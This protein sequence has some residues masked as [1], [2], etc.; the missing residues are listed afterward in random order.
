MEASLKLI[1]RG[2]Y[3]IINHPRQYGK[4]TLL[5]T[6]FQAL[7]RTEDYFAILINFQGIDRKWHESDTAFG[8]MFVDQMETILEVTD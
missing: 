6:L 5:Y 2:A 7:N 8:Q 1:E 3:F 4:T